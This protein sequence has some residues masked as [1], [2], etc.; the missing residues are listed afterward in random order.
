M[1]LLTIATLLVVLTALFGYINVR[2]LKLPV[3]IGLMIVSMGFSL[4]MIA[5]GFLDPSGAVY[6]A[7]MTTRKVIDCL[8]RNEMCAEAAKS[9]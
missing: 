5:V 9:L 6:I 3:T 4:L 1:E 8:G 7:D 2:F